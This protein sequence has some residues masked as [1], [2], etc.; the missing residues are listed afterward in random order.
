MDQ[1]G[2]GKR[3]KKVWK[4]LAVCVGAALA[5]AGIAV[6]GFAYQV[7]IGATYRTNDVEDYGEFEGFQGYS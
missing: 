1:K 3:T 6:G 4:I 5:A 7:I 2:N